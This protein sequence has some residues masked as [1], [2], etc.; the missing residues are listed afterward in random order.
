MRSRDELDWQQLPAIGKEK[1]RQV[2]AFIREPAIEQLTA[3]LAKQGVK[4]FQ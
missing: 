3:W 1:A 4:A 2:V